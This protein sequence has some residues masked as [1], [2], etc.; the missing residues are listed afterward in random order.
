MSV[1]KLT[2]ICRLVRGLS[3]RE[4]LAQLRFASSTKA[5]IVANTIRNARTAGVHNFGMDEERMVVAE[6]YATRAKSPKKLRYH[7]KGRTGIA[8]SHR[9]HVMVKLRQVPE[10]EG[11]KR[12][13][14]A[15]VKHETLRRT[16]ERL[17]TIQEQ[18]Q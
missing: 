9:S 12:V 8:R 7:S 6:C 14:R 16:K 3:V 1:K 17:A 11:E 15:G 4:A 5:W 18:E 13:G 10:E 2:E